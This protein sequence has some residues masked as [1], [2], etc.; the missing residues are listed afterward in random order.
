MEVKSRATRFRTASDATLVVSHCA[1]LIA[2]HSAAREASKAQLPALQ[3]RVRQVAR[4]RRRTRRLPRGCSRGVVSVIRVPRCTRTPAPEDRAWSTV[5]PSS[6]ASARKANCPGSVN[7]PPPSN[8][9]PFG[10][11]K[12]FRRPPISGCASRTATSAPAAARFRATTSPDRPAP[13]TA[14]RSTPEFFQNYSWE[15]F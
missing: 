7:S 15:Q 4:V 9:V 11:M 6:S 8:T 12:G 10:R 3:P 5:I 14:L 2:S 1:A 13:T